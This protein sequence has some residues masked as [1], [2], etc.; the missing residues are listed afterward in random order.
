MGLATTIVNSHYF[1]FGLSAGGFHLFSR[2]YRICILYFPQTL[3]FRRLSVTIVSL[4]LSADH[5][6]DGNFVPLSFSSMH[7]SIRYTHYHRPF[8]IGIFH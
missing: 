5:V 3:C 6:I 8:R 1:T 2:A 7:I 4:A